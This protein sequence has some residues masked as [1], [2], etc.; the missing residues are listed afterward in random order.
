MTDSW[1]PN[2]LIGFRDSFEKSRQIIRTVTTVAGID[3][4]KL[5]D[6]PTSSMIKF[7]DGFPVF[8][9]FYLAFVQPIRR[10]RQVRFFQSLPR[11]SI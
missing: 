7:Q 8:R 1:N 10:L 9:R 3:M 6:Q 4:T 2:A 11:R 5:I